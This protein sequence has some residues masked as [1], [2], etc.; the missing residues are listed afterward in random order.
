MKIPKSL[1]RMSKDTQRVLQWVASEFNYMKEVDDDL[2]RLIS[3][4]GKGEI[5][6]SERD[7]HHAIREFRYAG[8]SE[9][10]VNTNEEKMQ[11]D[12]QELMSILPDNFKKEIKE[13][14]KHIEVSVAFLI[15]NASMFEGHIKEHMNKLKTQVQL[16]DEEKK[17]KVVD[18]DRV[19]SH[20]AVIDAEINKLVQ[21]VELT[22]KWIAALAAE[23]ERVKEWEEKLMKMAA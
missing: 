6:K 9:R 15:S 13:L 23:I 8:R 11:K 12:I 3:D 14:D 2:H 22:L 10:R 5:K 7:I 20:K 21:R 18:L 4:L 16:L 19:K 17:R 1:K